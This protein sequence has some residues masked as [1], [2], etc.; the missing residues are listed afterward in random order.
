MLAEFGM[1]ARLHAHGGIGPNI[2]FTCYGKT[3]GIGSQ[4]MAKIMAMTLARHFGRRYLHAPFASIEHAPDS[5]TVWAVE[6]ERFLN[7]GE[8]EERLPADAEFIHVPALL[9]APEAYRDRPV[10]VGERMFHPDR[11]HVAPVLEALR[12]D[13]RARYWM[14][15][16]SRIP[17]RRGPSGSLTIAI[18]LRRGDIMPGNRFGRYEPDDA[19]LRA[20]RRLLRAVAPLGRPLTINLYSEGEAEQFRAFADLGCQL[21]ISTD[22]FESLHNLAAA[23]VLLM[24]RSSFSML[25]GLLSTGLVITPH[26]RPPRLGNWVQRSKSGELSIRR[27]R[28]ALLAKAGWRDIVLYQARRVRNWL[29]LPERV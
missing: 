3:D 24:G 13:L 15:D 10:V 18:H 7:L 12:R 20:V 17:L 5:P 11:R 14:T 2:A 27:V 9:N 4:A 26:P 28:Q 29:A 23:D 1:L 6:W 19:A 22:A 8:G 25:A 16:K 21:H